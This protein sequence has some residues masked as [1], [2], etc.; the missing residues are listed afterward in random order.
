MIQSLVFPMFLWIFSLTVLQAQPHEISAE[1]SRKL[2]ELIKQAG[3]LARNPELVAAVRDYNGKGRE[4]TKDMDQDT[5]T[6]LTIMD[7]IVKDL[8]SN[9]TAKFLQSKKSDV[10]SEA[11]VSGMDGTK[12]GF[13]SKPSNWSHKGKAKHDEP[14]AGKTWIGKPEKDASTGL[15]QVQFAL[16][17]VDGGK[18]IGSLVIGVAVNKL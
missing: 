10:M 3:D 9:A 12:V 13:L 17:I 7:P 1:Q 11:F 15:S 16:P 8:R 6:K 5:W 4:S 2:D 18:P 14:M